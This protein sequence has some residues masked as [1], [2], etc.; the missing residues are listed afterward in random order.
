MQNAPKLKES[1]LKNLARMFFSLLLLLPLA[2]LAAPDLVLKT[3]DGEQRNVSEYIGKGKWTIVAIWAHNC[4]VCNDEMPAMTFFHEAH[5]DKD[6][7]VLGVSIDGWAKR[8]K[9]KGFI[10]THA[11]NFPNLIAEPRQD[12]IGKFGGGEFYGT[13][14][15]YVYS[16]EG[17]LLARQ[18]GPI[19]AEDIEKFMKSVNQAKREKSGANG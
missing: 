13:P 3:V 15:F 5:K 10:E 8:Q 4:H 19:S 16:P 1:K 18:I 17:E 14:T 9:A 6:A 2:S 7:I 11:L 12:V